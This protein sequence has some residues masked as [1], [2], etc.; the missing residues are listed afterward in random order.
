M[1][2][3]KEIIRFYMDSPILVSEEYHRKGSFSAKGKLKK[4]EIAE[5]SWKE[6]RRK[7]QKETGLKRVWVRFPVW[8]S[9]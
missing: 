1:G 4:N 6:K 2:R 5:K 9:H 8:I 7:K 3:Q